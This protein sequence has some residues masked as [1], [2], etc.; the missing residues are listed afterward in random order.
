M[1]SSALSERSC[2]EERL[3]T[4]RI[5]PEMG[6]P[7]S[8][9]V[10]QQPFAPPALGDLLRAELMTGHWKSFRATV[11]F[12]KSSGVRYLSP[13]VDAF[14]S[15]GN[16][17]LTIS[18]GIDHD[19]TSLEALQDLWRVID[20]RGRLFV[21]KEG[22]GGGNRTFHPKVYLFASDSEALAV[23]G[24]GNLTAGGLYTN[25]ELSASIGLDLTDAASMTYL[26]ELR[27]ALDRW[28]TPGPACREVDASL[29]QDLYAAGDLLSEASIARAARASRAVTRSGTAAHT[30]GRSVLFGA[31]G[32]TTVP[33]QPAPMPALSSP[34]VTLPSLNRPAP[35]PNP[36][37]RSGSSSPSNAPSPHTAF[38][39]EV[40]PHHNGEVFLSKTAVDDDP[41]FFGYPFTGWTIPHRA[42][43][44]PYPMV[45]PDPEIEIIVY[46][47]Q[48]AVQLRAQHEL[49]VVYYTRK[50]EIR[51]TIPPVPL[52]SIPQM[53]LLVMTRNPTPTL[54]Y[55][56]EFF[57]PNCNDPRAR[58]F[59]S[60]LVN[61]LPSGGASDKRRYGWV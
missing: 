30:T 16:V 22:Q 5:L 1:N 26:A 39:I 14:L 41:G 29:I 27:T 18:V 48:G 15:G 61:E 56:L 49:N 58:Q 17:H 31:S 54:D 53:S 35:S 55:W 24:S 40:K 3:F 42:N 12:L 10:I 59:G 19:G 50:S 4:R 46:D 28:Q 25:H 2:A 52:A 43:N 21:F 33:P 47:S 20:G 23:I 57:P 9:R 51:I 34:P 8:L 7:P 36:A 44:P 11:A 38:L 60:Y 45:S 6:R 32:A 13:P 37:V